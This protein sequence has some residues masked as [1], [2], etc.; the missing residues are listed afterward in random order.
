MGMVRPRRFYST[1]G[2]ILRVCPRGPDLR[3]QGGRL[4]SGVNSTGGT[5]VARKVPSVPRTTPSVTPTAP[6]VTRASRP[7]QRC[8]SLRPCGDVGGFFR[9]IARSRAG[10]R[11]LG[12]RLGRGVRRRRGAFGSLPLP[13][14]AVKEAG[15]DRG[16]P[17]H[18]PRRRQQCRER[19][20][21]PPEAPP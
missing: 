10:D 5:P 8:E 18:V 16:L 9:G 1:G 4:G 15:V 11:R 20:R 2:M 7:C 12:R 14:P 21:G 6:S 19:E 13:L 17:Q 3:N